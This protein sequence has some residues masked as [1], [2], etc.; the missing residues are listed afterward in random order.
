MKSTRLLENIFISAIN[1]MAGIDFVL[2]CVQN[3]K[4]CCGSK[5]LLRLERSEMKKPPS[6]GF[7]YKK[8]IS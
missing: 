4:I 1:I 6:F 7:W 2:G 5:D 8:L 3:R